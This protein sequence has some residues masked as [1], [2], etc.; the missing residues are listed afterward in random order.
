M[1]YFYKNFFFYY[2]NL[3]S[4]K[5]KLLFCFWLSFGCPRN[6]N[7]CIKLYA[8]KVTPLLFFILNEINRFAE[9][10]TINKTSK[11][12]KDVILVTNMGT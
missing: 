2:Y 7:F 4:L 9:I 1:V 3:Y 11:C 5:F 8:A 12:K 6:N 10:Q